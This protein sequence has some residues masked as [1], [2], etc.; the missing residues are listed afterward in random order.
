MCE[1]WGALSFGGTDLITAAQELAASD[2]SGQLWA[3]AITA[4]VGV[5]AVLLRAHS[6]TL[7]KAERLTELAAK[8]PES[9]ERTLVEDL[10]NDYVTSWALSQM[11]PGYGTYRVKSVIL[12]SFGGLTLFAWIVFAIV[13]SGALWTWWWYFAGLAFVFAGLWVEAL[14]FRK[15][16]TWIREERANRWMRL[17]M[18]NRL[19]EAIIPPA[20][21]R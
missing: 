14:R 12:Y 15:R 7:R 18:H 6:G 21:S 8:M 3:A 4:V 13:F 1:A 19:R 11:A 17:P 10:R 2:F 20:R 9:T 5:V 16:G